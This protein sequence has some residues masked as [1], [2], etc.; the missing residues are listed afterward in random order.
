MKKYLIVLLLLG[1]VGVVWGQREEDVLTKL[2]R[3]YRINNS[4]KKATKSKDTKID[5]KTIDSISKLYESR[6]YGRVNKGVR[7]KETNT[8]VVEYNFGQGVFSRNRLAARV[9]YPMVF[10]ITNINRLAYDI[11]ISSIDSILA[12]SLIAD[13][14]SKWIPAASPVKPETIIVK[15]PT[16]LIQSIFLRMMLSIKGKIPRIK[17]KLLLLTLKIFSI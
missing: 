7:P 4:T 17:S 11:N 12:N 5:D 15:Q 10:K 13:D 16:N 3:K 14:L 2:E 6:I 1:W 9:N 8:Y